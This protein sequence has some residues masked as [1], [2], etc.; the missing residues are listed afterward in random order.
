[1]HDKNPIQK[2]T[3]EILLLAS[4]LLHHNQLVA[5]PTETVYGL[6]ANALSVEAVQRI[7]STK[8]RPSNNP[9]IVHVPNKESAQ[10]VA[11]SWPPLAEKLASLFW[12]GPLT[13]VLPKHSSIPAAVSGG[14][15]TVAVRVPRH[16]IALKLLETCRLPLVGPSANPSEKISPTTPEHVRKGLPSV[17]LILDGGPCL[18]GI[19]STVIDLTQSTPVLL[20][21]GALSFS[22]LQEVVPD[23]VMFNKTL[24]KDQ[25]QASP[26]MMMRH[27]APN[28]Q[29][30]L[31]EN[32]ES[33]D[34]SLFCSPM[35]LLLNSPL[36]CSLADKNILIER[37][38]SNPE[39]YAAEL[40][41]ALHR[42]DDL[43]I[44]TIIVQPLPDGMEW[45]AVKDRL[46][47]AASK[48]GCHYS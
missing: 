18:F 24:H 23:L 15:N 28:A 47:R 31:A 2:P 3:Q 48:K 44:A 33:L 43:N 39:S 10:T 1:M 34:L 8:G 16:P 41:A 14:G 42:L 7:Y 5:F 17:P 19:E 11:A 36:S 20:R 22:K 35:A 38:P 30:I 9:L 26:G 40:F 6:G 13:L 45:W 46:Q 25:Q 12:P 27:Y 4:K 37:L 29:V 21:P 32:I